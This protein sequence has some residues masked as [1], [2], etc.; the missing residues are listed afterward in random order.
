MAAREDQLRELDDLVIKMQRAQAGMSPSGRISLTVEDSRAAHK[1]AGLGPGAS[2]S[3]VI[4][5][6]QNRRA[7]LLAGVPKGDYVKYIKDDLNARRGNARGQVQFN[8]DTR[9]WI[10][11]HVYGRQNWR[12]LSNARHWPR[13]TVGLEQLLADAKRRAGMEAAP[14]ARPAPTREHDSERTGLVDKCIKLQNGDPSMY[15][16]IGFKKG[17]VAGLGA[18]RHTIR[19][20]NEDGVL[21]DRA[22]K[23]LLERRGNGGTSYEKVACPTSSH[24]AARMRAMADAGRPGAPSD[25]RVERREEASRGNMRHNWAATSAAAAAAAIADEDRGPMGRAFDRVGESVRRSRRPR[26][27][28]VTWGD[29]GDDGSDRPYT[30]QRAPLTAK[31]AQAR[32]DRNQRRNDT[33]LESY[34]GGARKT[35]RGRRRRR[36]GRKTRSRTRG[37]RTTRRSR[38]TRSKRRGHRTRARRRRR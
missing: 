29:G 12:D 5:E 3:S 34:H 24:H 25:R 15:K 38:R 14:H 33:G 19:A 22:R 35:R 10:L 9:R 37:R 28:R 21:F 32:I 11:D 26:R 23:E 31:Q 30:P 7:A 17:R 20:I 36:V 4:D 13:D 6:L 1:A 27:E 18:S 8:L 2:L 16:V